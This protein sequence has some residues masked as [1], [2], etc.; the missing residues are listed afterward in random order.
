MS[1]ASYRLPIGPDS[2]R[3]ARAVALLGGAL[4]AGTTS[5]GAQA[6]GRL[7]G[8]VTDS[9]RAAP[10]AGAR[11]SVTR[12]GAE[13]ET[14]HV[15]TTDAKGKFAFD[16]LDAGLYAIGFSNALLDS[17]EFGGPVRRVAVVPDGVARSARTTA[18]GTTAMCRAGPP[19]SSE[20]SRA[21]EN[22]IA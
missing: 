21:L 13:R 6:P 10:L 20:S 18:S 14:T 5:V 22:P 12:L 4:L 8:T 16:R 15:A 7:E 9:T 3:R 11:V 17:L 19:N 2:L 1:L